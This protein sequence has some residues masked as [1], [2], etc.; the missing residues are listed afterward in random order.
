VVNECS[1]ALVR[2]STTAKARISIHKKLP[3]PQKV[4]IEETEDEDEARTQGKDDENRSNREQTD[5]ELTGKEGTPAE[6]QSQQMQGEMDA[7]FEL[8]GSGVVHGDYSKFAA[9]PSKGGFE[10]ASDSGDEE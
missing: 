5:F 1:S 6:N 10:L 7:Q 3:L 4:I 9:K 8:E 2:I